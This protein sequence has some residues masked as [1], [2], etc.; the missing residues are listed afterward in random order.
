[1]TAALPFEVR[2]L[3]RSLAFSVPDEFAF[4]L[5]DVPPADGP[6]TLEPL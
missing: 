1:V 4:S 6:P 2:E 5:A 3:L